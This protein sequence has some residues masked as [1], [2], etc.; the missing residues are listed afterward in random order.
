MALPRLFTRR[1]NSGTKSS[2]GKPFNL[3][4]TAAKRLMQGHDLLGAIQKLE[5]A[6]SVDSGLA[7]TH[8]QLALALNDRHAELQAPP[9][10]VQKL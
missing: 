7:E 3:A 8:F 1:R 9:E 6:L 5:F 4:T 10:S 2:C